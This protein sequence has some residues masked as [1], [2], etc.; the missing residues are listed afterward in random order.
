MQF[1]D[2]NKESRQFGNIPKTIPSSP[3]LF[4][5]D[6]QNQVNAMLGGSTNDQYLGGMKPTNPMVA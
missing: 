3:K 4:D 1:T 5:K 2:V 6:D